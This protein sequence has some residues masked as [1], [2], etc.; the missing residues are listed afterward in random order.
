M[1]SVHF[2]FNLKHT[3]GLRR[4]RRLIQWN[5][6][7]SPISGP[8]RIQYVLIIIII[9][10]Y[11]FSFDK[12]HVGCMDIYQHRLQCH[13]FYAI[14]TMLHYLFQYPVERGIPVRQGSLS[15]MVVGYP[16]VTVVLIITKQ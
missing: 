6:L 9:I 7:I 16:S 5:C 4:R 14:L 11:L 10:I 1:S 12:V 3:E 2:H 8:D 15:T 13:S